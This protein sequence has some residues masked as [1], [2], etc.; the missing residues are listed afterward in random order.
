MATYIGNTF[1]PSVQKISTIPSIT[2]QE[3]FQISKNKIKAKGHLAFS[4]KELLI[5]NKQKTTQL[6]Y[7][8]IIE[9]ETPIGSWEVLVNAHNGNVISA[10]DKANYYQHS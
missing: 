8:V 7:K 2:E 6:I 3:A 5:Y 10:K 4:S 1:D 9:S